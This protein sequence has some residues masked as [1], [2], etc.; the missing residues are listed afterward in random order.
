MSIRKVLKGIE[1]YKKLREDNPDY[2]GYSDRISELG[3]ILKDLCRNLVKKIP[4]DIT[5]R[6]IRNNIIKN[7]TSGK[8]NNLKE[9]KAYIKKNPSSQG[10]GIYGGSLITNLMCKNIL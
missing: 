8:I 6:N 5:D 10:E 4:K 7:I 2:D 1:K 9:I 3:Y